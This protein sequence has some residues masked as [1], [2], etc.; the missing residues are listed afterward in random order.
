MLR[1]C[2]VIGV[3]TFALYVAAPDASAQMNIIVSGSL[4][5]LDANGDS[6]AGE[7]AILNAV[8]ACWAARVPTQRTF[9]LNVTTNAKS[10][11]TI[12]QGAISA[13]N[14]SGIPTAGGISFD[15]DGS[16]SYYVDTTPL[17]SIEFTPDPNSRWRYIDGPTSGVDLYSVVNHEVG[18]AMAWLCGASCGF[19]NP[20]YDARMN[21]SPGNFLADPGCDG[22]FPILGQPG[23]AGCVH[24]QGN[25]PAMD[26]PL[27][28]DG[29]GSDIV[30][31]LSH[32]GIDDD[33]MLGFYDDGSR[34]FQSRND[35]L[36]FAN[37]YSDTINLPPLINAGSN[38]IA[39]CNATGGAN[40][41]L[42]GS[43]TDPED[44]L[45]FH[46]ACGS[47]SL[48]GAFTA[49]PSGFFALNS[50]TTCRMEVTDVAVCPASGDEM[51]VQ[52]RDTTAPIITCP[53]PIQAEC[54]AT[55]GTPKTDSQLSAFLSGASATDVCDATLTISASAPA[56]FPV[57]T[58]TAVLFS[59]QDDSSNAAS[60]SANVTVV[61]TTPPVV[62]AVTA[63]PNVLTPYTH[64][65]VP[66]T[67]TAEVSDLCDATASCEIY[68]VTSDE[69]INGPGDG[70]TLPDYVITGPLTV[71]LR[72]ERDGRGDGRVYTIHVRCTDDYGNVS[73]K[74]VD[75]VVPHNAT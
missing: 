50:T 6:G 48:T 70:S 19:N 14:G 61:D 44:S 15:N 62:G 38:R 73:T 68:Q 8:V 17:D 12:G 1:Q 23:L 11:G 59:T 24:L 30:N 60:C 26:I 43:G 22:P 34:E 42:S 64:K 10:G 3:C 35:V 45:A 55:G 7:A 36:I 39:E 63:S 13:V 58:A 40:V 67:V 29:V 46:W 2:A 33:L 52:V 28:G 18:H 5:D 32:P 65:L 72:S 25:S 4:G 54:T 74:T 16:T 47:V 75:V 57:G 56:L 21:P 49:T 53:A 27:R 9:T 51:T 69:A 37:A 31:E 20:N 71:Q 66:V 41:T